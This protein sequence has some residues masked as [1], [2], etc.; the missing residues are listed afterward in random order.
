MPIIT[1][2]VAPPKDCYQNSTAI[3][4]GD[5]IEFEA[6][7][8]C[9]SINLTIEKCYNDGNNLTLVFSGIEHFSTENKFSKI[10]FYFSSRT[11]AWEGDE[12]PLPA[13]STI[14]KEN[15]TFIIIAPIGEKRIE[16]AQITIPYCYNKLS[17]ERQKVYPETQRG[18]T[19]KFNEFREPEVIKIKTNM[20]EKPY[21]EAPKNET[22]I[23]TEESER[24]STIGNRW[25]LPLLIVVVVV[26]G[27]LA[28]RPKK[29]KTKKKSAKKKK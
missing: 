23:P 3:K 25:V 17:N 24:K 13:N 29:N 20:T 19:C 4:C 14:R 2:A 21:T 6:E 15:D 7:Q 28:L 11:W 16:A 8:Y 9:E 22:N 27:V 18:K 26:I 1:G 10:K 12:T 5:Q